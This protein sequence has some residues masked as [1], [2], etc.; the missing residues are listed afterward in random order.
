MK[1]SLTLLA[2]VLLGSIVASSQKFEILQIQISKIEKDHGYIVEKDWTEYNG[3]L[4]FK[5][6]TMYWGNEGDESGWVK[7][8]MKIAPVEEVKEN[9]RRECSAWIS[10]NVPN[11]DILIDIKYY[12]DGTIIIDYVVLNHI[13][14]FMCKIV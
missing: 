7:H 11:G 13:I 8:T 10:E 5:D 1:R 2:I 14:K 4:A 6:S 9:F 3:F 12:N